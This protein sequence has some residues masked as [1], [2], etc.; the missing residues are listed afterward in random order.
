MARWS[1]NQAHTAAE[2]CVR[3]MMITPVRGQFKNLSGTLDF[4]PARP[5]EAWA[6][7]SIEA[8]TLWSGEPER[9][10][11]LRSPDFLDV[12]RYPMIHFRSTR[13]EPAGRTEYRVTG[14]LTIRGVTRPVT[15]D[16]RYLGQCR[17]PFDDTR[18]GFTATARL[19]RRDFGVSWNADLRDHGVVVGNE[20]EIT[21]DV[22]AEIPDAPSPPEGERPDAPPAS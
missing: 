16:V 10:D 1:F 5:E 15:L 20:V 2:F 19:D 3:H 17:S 18:A 7:V 9:D 11:H 14:D 8:A 22:E 6:E 12:A 21:I 4:D 13:V